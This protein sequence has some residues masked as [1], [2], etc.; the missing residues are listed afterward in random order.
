MSNRERMCYDCGNFSL[1]YFCGYESC[2]CKIFGSLDVDQQERHPDITAETCPEF[3]PKKK[4]PLTEKERIKKWQRALW[5]NG[6][7][8]RRR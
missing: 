6:Y 2:N 3:T 7:H 8:Q 4:K 1:S 5:P